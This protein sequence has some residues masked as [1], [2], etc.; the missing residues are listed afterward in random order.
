[1]EKQK[2]VKK[3]PMMLEKETKHAIR[4][5][6]LIE[7]SVLEL[8]G[9]RPFDDVT[10]LDICD[11]ALIT[12]ATFYKYYEDKYHLIM[13]VLDD[14]IE[15]LFQKAGKKYIIKGGGDSLAAKSCRTLVTPWTVAH[16][17]YCTAG[18]ISI[19]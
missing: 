17:V 11:K 19:D 1:M 12:R 14:H 18:R 6:N 10:V 4:T 15:N 9:D 7:R 16:P 5:R 8:M 3:V 13:C 2:T